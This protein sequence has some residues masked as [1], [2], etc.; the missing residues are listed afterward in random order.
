MKQSIRMTALTA[1]LGVLFLAAPA[2]AQTSPFAEPA[3]GVAHYDMSFYRL[4]TRQQPAAAA[5][6][7]CAD[8]GADRLLIVTGETGENMDLISTPLTS[9]GGSVE[10]HA[11][12]LKQPDGGA[13]QI[14]LP[15]AG[16]A[17]GNLHF[18]HAGNYGDP[19][20]IDAPALIGIT[21]G[22]HNYGCFYQ[23]GLRY[24]AASWDGLLTV[25]QDIDANEPAQ[26][27]VQHY[28]GDPGKP[29]WTAPVYAIGGSPA[30]RVGIVAV[31]DSGKLVLL[32]AQGSG[33]DRLSDLAVDG[34]AGGGPPRAD[35]LSMRSFS[36]YSVPAHVDADLVPHLIDLRVCAHVAGETGSGNPQREAALSATWKQNRCGGLKSAHR[37]YLELYGADAVLGPELRRWK[38]DPNGVPYA[39]GD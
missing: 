39:E 35:W 29:D 18:T 26:L 11:I 12:D 20:R 19:R 2:E 8:L 6:A 22:H 28:L 3:K 21:L 10:I 4:T 15:F 14:Y 37:R 16:A 31:R 23:P 33:D 13:G 25:E 9:L 36:H 5:L 7:L 38:F 17:T 24:L 1:L 34:G 27:V 32:S 30:T